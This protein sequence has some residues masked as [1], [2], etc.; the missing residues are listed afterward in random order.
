LFTG[1]TGTLDT[2]FASDI[3]LFNTGSTLQT[4]INNLSNTY[5]TITNLASTGS[6]LAT[7]LAA[8]GAT[9]QTNINNL[10]NTYATITNVGLTGIT[11][12][13]SINSLS[14]LFTG[15]TGTLDTSYATDL[16]VTNTGITLNTRINNLSG[17]I[18]S[19]S[20]NI[21]FTTGNQTISGVKTF[22]QD[23]TFGD[24]GQGDFLV[25][26]GNNFTVYGSGNF[27]SGLFVNGNAVL[28]GVNLTP[29]AT[30]AN[31]ALTGNTLTNN[32]TSL[33]GLFTG[34]TGALD[35]TYA[36]D[37]QLFTTGSTLQTN[38]NNLSG[39][40]NSTSS[41]ILFT[42]GNQ[43]ISGLKTFNTGLSTTYISGVSGISLNIL[44]YSDSISA[45][46]LRNINITAGL[47][48]S[49]INAGDIILIGGNLS[50]VS[51][52]ILKTG[53]SITIGG[54][55]T[56]T[57]TSDITIKPSIDQNGTVGNIVLEA[58]ASTTYNGKINMFGDININGTSDGGTALS[59]KNINIY[60]RGDF[61]GSPSQRLA[62]SIDNNN[63]N[64]QNGMGLQVSGVQVTPALYATSANLA[65]TGSTLQTN[66]NNLSSTY[67]TIT[68]VGLTGSTLTNNITS[69]SGL[70]T[71]YTGNLDLTFATDLQVT[72]TGITLNTRINNLSGYINSSSSNIVFTTGNQNIGGTKTFTN[73]TSNISIK[74]QNSGLEINSGPFIIR[75][76]AGT[77]GAARV[78]ILNEGGAN[79][80]TVINEGLDLADFGLQS[81]TNK[82]I[83]F[84]MEGREAYSNGNNQ[85]FQ[86]IDVSED[87]NGAYYARFG[88]NNIVI[89]ENS[90]KIGI[91]TLSPVT[92]LHVKGTSDDVT[93]PIAIVE[94][95]GTQAPYTFRVDGTDQAYV[96]GD[97]AGNLAFGAQN[98]IVFEAGGFG[99][100]A[101]KIRIQ[102]DGKIGIGTN[103]PLRK[104]HQSDGKFLVNSAEGGYGQFQITNPELGEVTAVFAAEATINEDGSLSS[105][106]NDYIWA[107]GLGSYGNT[108]DK[109]IIGNNSIGNS[110][111]TVTASGNI[112][113]GTLTPS[114]K[115][116]VNGN[117]KAMGSINISGSYDLYSQIENAKKLAIAYAIAL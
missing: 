30:T 116:E 26:S 114:E 49:T 99:A 74:P 77:Y 110:A 104:F 19:T 21:V 20:S 63:V 54:A 85:E 50:G 83:N 72:N 6:T 81:S 12:N 10:S 51:P 53:A 59:S 23:A 29:Y 89:G 98:F 65:S 117:I 37:T 42:T 73:G 75:S 52:N 69:L 113:V 16:Q 71:G 46:T 111:F 82:K 40:V 48:T 43:I 107:F 2:I 109:F 106:N 62:V 64:F 79:G 92:K 80:F 15:Y 32:I 9:L 103:T 8:T 17:Y 56:T 28:T 41:N 34:Y 22:V 94:S 96:K 11:L 7:N 115:L 97:D 60:R 47:G 61:F 36:T 76:A 68:N 88:N 91:G 18:N 87:A 95:D 45:Q 38:I 93:S 78:E 31:L 55:K 33:S 24:T 57:S 1:Y 105:T 108:S 66:I 14:G 102:A 100:G 35:A 44:G 70:F 67:A 4:N 39:Y 58:G 13:S 27:T 5:A 112:G 25:I 3:Q 90:E 101:E 84:R 86:I